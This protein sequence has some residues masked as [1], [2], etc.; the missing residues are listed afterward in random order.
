MLV[1]L[2]ALFVTL[3]FVAAAGRSGL[4]Q[5][6]IYASAAYTL[7][8]VCST[9]FLSFFGWL[10][11]EAVL[12]FWTLMTTLAAVWLWRH[13]D[14]DALLS[15]LR[16]AASC[17]LPQKITL[18]AAAAVLAVVLA[19]ALVAPPNNW[20]SIAYRIMRVAMWIDQQS[21]S[22]YPTANIVQL[23]YP[24]LVSWQSMHLQILAHGDRF[25]NMPEWMALAGCGVVA[26]LITKELSV[27]FSVQ[28][29]AAVVAVTLP[30]GLLQGSSTAANLSAAYWLMC[31]LLLFIQHLRTPTLLRLAGCGLA[32]GFALLAKPTAYV[33]GPPVALTLVLY[34]FF[35]GAGRSGSWRS[36]EARPGIEQHQRACSASARKYSN[37]MLLC[38]LSMAGASVIALTL[39]LGHYSRN[40]IVFDHPLSPSEADNQL[41]ERFDAELVTSNLLWNAAVHWGTPSKDINAAVVDAI[42]MV[43]GVLGVTREGGAL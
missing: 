9:E 30:M 16:S 1:A 22:H 26:S 28:V 24:P 37:P 42:K 3:L 4:R 17:T 35:H 13:G 2:P 14:R 31:F 15:K 27:R 23:Y 19:I 40:W 6:F 21:I 25:A 20:E 18:A 33:I 32:L 39:N 43:L 38:V 36:R 11:F 7:C 34:G 8:V 12:A 29:L 41:N 5:G 10:R